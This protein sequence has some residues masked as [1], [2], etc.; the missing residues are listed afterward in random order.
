M[1]DEYRRDFRDGQREFYWSLPRLVVGGLVFIMLIGGLG[2]VVK[3]IAQP[4]RIISK[5]F[6][7]DNVINTY[8]WYRDA[9][10]NYLAR[11]AQVRQFKQLREEEKSEPERARL[12]VEMAAIQQSCRDL[13][14]RYN[15]NAD[16]I[17]KSIFMGTS[18]PAALNA[19]D[20]E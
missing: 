2:F 18:V 20:C 1:N 9:Y 4:G 6:D 17:N 5:T 14:R 11:L 13:A 12:R 15:A 3:M 10:G 8:E 7:A 19:T 16:K